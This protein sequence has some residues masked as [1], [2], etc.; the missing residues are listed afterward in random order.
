MGSEISQN[1]S[2]RIIQKGGVKNILWGEVLEEIKEEVNWGSQ[3]Q[4]SSG[5]EENTGE[6][7]KNK[8]NTARSYV[9]TLAEIIPGFIEKKLLNVP[10]GDLHKQ[11]LIATE[12]NC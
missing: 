10:Q 11:D 8:K 2:E 1:Q 4:E 3:R 7:L 9:Q 12:K 6:E 5:E